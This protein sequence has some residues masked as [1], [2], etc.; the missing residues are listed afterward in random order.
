MTKPFHEHYS[1]VMEGPTGTR[2][3]RKI[4]LLKKKGSSVRDCAR[5]FAAR[6][7]G[8][9]ISQLRLSAS[10]ILPQ[11]FSMPIMSTTPLL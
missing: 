1:F 3:E 8:S 6:I 2:A 10:S 7:G 5:Y 11:K 9:T 4:D